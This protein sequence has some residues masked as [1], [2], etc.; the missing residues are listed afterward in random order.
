[1]IQSAAAV[2]DVDALQRAPDAERIAIALA[3]RELHDPNNSQSQ[4]DEWSRALG[5]QIIDY[6]STDLRFVWPT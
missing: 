6:L 4:R 1:V 3:W 5:R 2:I